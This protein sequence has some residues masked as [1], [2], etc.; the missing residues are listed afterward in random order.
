MAQ[1]MAQLAQHMTPQPL[2]QHELAD[3]MATLGRRL[4]DQHPHDVLTLAGFLATNAL[5]CWNPKD[6]IPLAAEWC[7]NVLATLRES[8]D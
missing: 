7:D 8:L 2:A 3:M 5:R 6:R 1:L 4:Y